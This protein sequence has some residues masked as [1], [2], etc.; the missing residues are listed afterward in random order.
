MSRTEHFNERLQS[1]QEQLDKARADYDVID[2]QIDALYDQRWPIS[3]AIAGMEMDIE[4]IQDGLR[5]LANE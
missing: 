2:K 1:L 4:E 5:D 3:M